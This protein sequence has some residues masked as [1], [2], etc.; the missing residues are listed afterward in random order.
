M[1]E[2]S[3]RIDEN[4]ITKGLFFIAL[5]IVLLIYVNTPVLFSLILLIIFIMTYKCPAAGI[6]AFFVVLPLENFMV[7]GFPIA[8]I[9]AVAIVVLA[10]I[11]IGI[12]FRPAWEIPSIKNSIIY[13]VFF[14]LA[15]FTLMVSQKFTGLNYYIIYVISLTVSLLSVWVIIIEPKSIKIIAKAILF[16]VIISFVLGTFDIQTLG[17]LSYNSSTRT[18]ANAAGLAAFFLFYQIYI[19]SLKQGFPLIDY[20]NK[21]LMFL[22]AM[23]IIVLSSNRGVM[24]AT[25][26]GI[27]VSFFCDIFFRTQM[28]KMSLNVKAIVKFVL[29][30]ASLITLVI[31]VDNLLFSGNFLNARLISRLS[32]MAPGS[33]ENIRYEIWKAAISQLDEYQLFFGAGIG[34]FREYAIAG[35]KDYYAHSLFVDLIVTQGLL[36]FFVLVAF[37]AKLAIK[38]CLKGDSF[39]LGLLAYTIT[40]YYTYGAVHNAYQFWVLFGFIY[41]VSQLRTIKVQ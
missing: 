13:F 22:I 38:F 2:K 15:L 28:N 10:G 4:K 25:M 33:R 23:A 8:A 18:V 12:L 39:G 26:V 29:V 7:M 19:G 16:S 20:K 21:G 9:T 24:L 30:I 14:G 41:G 40:S 37:M 32:E 5:S 31:V 34:T 17:R 11:I 35:G 1:L 36:A 3:I 27:T 6:A